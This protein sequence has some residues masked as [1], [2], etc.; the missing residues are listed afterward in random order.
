M[1]TNKYDREILDKFLYEKQT[2]LK[3]ELFPLEPIE[4]SHLIVDWLNIFPNIKIFS[5]F[6]IKDEYEKN[7]QYFTLDSDLDIMEYIPDKHYFSMNINEDIK[8]KIIGLF[9]TEEKKLDK[10]IIDKVYYALFGENNK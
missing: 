6:K 8:D 7:Y 9:N 4:L 1:N 2:T 10:E 3:M 5:I